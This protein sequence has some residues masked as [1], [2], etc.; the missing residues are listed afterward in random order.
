MR[1]SAISRTAH[2]AAHAAPAPSSSKAADDSFAALLQTAAPK[3]GNKAGETATDKSSEKTDSK[4]AEKDVGDD[5]EIPAADTALTQGADSK[6]VSAQI[7]SAAKSAKDDNT[8]PA[9]ALPDDDTAPLP[10]AASL[11]VQTQPQPQPQPQLPPQMMVLATPAPQP[12]KSDTDSNTDALSAT[13]ASGAAQGADAGHDLQPDAAAPKPASQDIKPDASLTTGKAQAKPAP[14][15][16]APA[17]KADK[18]DKTDIG[19]VDPKP[20]SDKPDAKLAAA[21]PAI[22]DT[23][24][25][26]APQPAAAPDT[27]VTIAAPQTIQSGQTA[28]MT[29]PGITQHVQVTAHAPEATP[30]LPALAVQIAAKSQ[31]GSKQF[32]IRLDPPELG[33]VDVRLSIDASGKTSAHLTADQPQTLDLLQKDST[34]LTQALR[35]AGLNVSQDGLNF[36]LRQQNQQAGQQNGQAPDFARSALVATT[37]VNPSITSAAW[38]APA[39]GRLDIR[40]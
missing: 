24:A 7:K 38:R 1:T 36:S 25:K 2:A 15:K 40:V 8:D 10:D 32:D 31:S 14:D 28:G 11:Q 18:A 20:D 6:S 29:A 4:A 5:R 17:A 22:A 30:N 34:S 27:N 37:T 13:A 21:A 12:S 23:P 39:D 33:R 3:A 26:P 9:A 16:G 19:K 35:D